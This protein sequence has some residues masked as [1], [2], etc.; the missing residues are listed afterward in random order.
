VYS[1][2]RAELSDVDAMAYVH[3]TSWKETY[4]GLLDNNVIDK[5]DLEN[6]KKMWAGFLQKDCTSIAYV[7]RASEKIEAIASSQ[8]IM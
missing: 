7:A 8:R 4:K 5:F 6:R 2:R 1:F 3:V